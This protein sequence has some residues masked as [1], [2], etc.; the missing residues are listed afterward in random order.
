MCFVVMYSGYGADSYADPLGAADPY[1]QPRYEVAVSICSG[2][3]TPFP[4]SKFN[5]G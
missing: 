2:L 1:M 4:I 3:L 5:Y